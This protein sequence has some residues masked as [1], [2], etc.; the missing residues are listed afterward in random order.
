MAEQSL[1][2]Q[3][4]SG[5]IIGNTYMN[6]YH[7]MTP[8]VI[9]DSRINFVPVYIQDALRTCINISKSTIKIGNYIY[10]NNATAYN[11]FYLTNNKI[12]QYSQFS[13]Y[14]NSFT[15]GE[16]NFYLSLTDDDNYIYITNENGIISP[17]KAFNYYGVLSVISTTSTTD[18]YRFNSNVE[19]IIC[20]FKNISKTASYKYK[21]DG[22]TEVTT[23]VMP[24]IN[25]VNIPVN[26]NTN[27][28][29]LDNLRVFALMLNERGKINE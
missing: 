24:N 27:S 28:I 4:L 21:Y 20:T 19:N 11:P 5:Q 15:I 3:G 22:S 29:K 8:Y 23:I 2:G 26:S 13:I 6:V 12:V 10:P 18:T 17:V 14:D 7:M 1:L 25:Y 9:G 16:N